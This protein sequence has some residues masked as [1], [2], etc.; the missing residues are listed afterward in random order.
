MATFAFIGRRPS[1]GIA[2]YGDTYLQCVCDS[3]F[4]LA[5][6]ARAFAR[7]ATMS[8]MF[9]FEKELAEAAEMLNDGDEDLFAEV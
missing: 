6:V 4:I 3:A 9:A 8:D 5:R 1:P 2:C 7:S